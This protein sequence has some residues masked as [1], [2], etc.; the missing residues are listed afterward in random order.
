M[1]FPCRLPTRVKSS[2]YLAHPSPLIDRC[3]FHLGIFEKKCF[4]WGEEVVLLVYR[5]FFLSFFS[6]PAWRGIAWV[7]IQVIMRVWVFASDFALKPI[8]MYLV[9]CVAN[10]T[11]R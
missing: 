2:P 4:V 10:H 7:V 8:G 5:F 9:V 3:F 6:T 11:S 1:Y